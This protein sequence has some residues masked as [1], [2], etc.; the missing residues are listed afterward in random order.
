MREEYCAY[1]GVD[2]DVGC[3]RDLALSDESASCCANAL[4]G[5]IAL[6]YSSN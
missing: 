4:D 3:S 6:F 1:C 2:S 5:L